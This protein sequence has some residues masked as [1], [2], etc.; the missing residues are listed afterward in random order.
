MRSVDT[1][2]FS[3][4]WLF[5]SGDTPWWQPTGEKFDAVLDRWH[6]VNLPHCF[7]ADD[8]FTPSRSFYR[9]V[10][11]YRKTFALPEQ[12]GD[13]QVFLEFGAAFSLADVWVNEHHLGQFMGGF[14]GFSVDATEF[15]RP[16]ENLV[17]VKVDSSHHPDIL[18]G[19]FP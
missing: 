15:L 16:G 12:L 2:Q 9:G 4:G 3:Q 19:F 7:N 18:P 17:A 8:T 6:E 13:R 14:T 11:W 1:K 5:H 10:C